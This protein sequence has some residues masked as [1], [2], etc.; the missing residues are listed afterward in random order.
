MG[1]PLV[2]FLES[3]RLGSAGQERVDEGPEIMQPVPQMS[4]N[5]LHI[6]L[7][8]AWHAQYAHAVLLSIFVNVV[9]KGSRNYI[10]K[11]VI[12]V[13]FPSPAPNFLSN[14]NQQRLKR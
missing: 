13:R 14:I 7:L 8:D 3:L 10:P 6:Q 11:L 4:R 1:N 2:P 9:N 5:Y 12:R